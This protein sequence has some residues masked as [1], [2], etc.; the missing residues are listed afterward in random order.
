MV[1]TDAPALLLT[2]D[3]FLAMPE[4]AGFELVHGRVE[5]IPMGGQSSWLGGEMHG[6]FRDFLKIHP[7]GRVF[8]QETGIAVWAD[9]PNHVRKPDVMFIARGRL[10]G[11]KL[12]EGWIT[13]V[14]DL[15]VEVLS[16]NDEAQKLDAKLDDYRRAG[17]GVIWVVY[18]ETR[19]AYVYERGAPIREVEE[20]GLLE[21]PALLPGF[22]L[23]LRELF[24]AADAEL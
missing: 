9:A 5:E 3:E 24:A 15:V 19:K 18:P 10:P 6:V 12:P 17:I 7:L 2:A 13:V 23:S 20:D 21:A 14:P 1:T 4:N 11:G 16:P 22:S 8:P